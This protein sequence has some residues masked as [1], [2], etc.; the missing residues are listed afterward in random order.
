MC[1]PAAMK[2]NEPFGHLTINGGLAHTDATC[3][4]QDSIGLIWIG[5]Y[6]GLQSY[7]GYSLRRFDYYSQEQNIYEAHNRIRTMMCAGD[8][9]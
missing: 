6:A 2:G 3:I 9:L 4:A 7:D 1:L 8:Y 5:T